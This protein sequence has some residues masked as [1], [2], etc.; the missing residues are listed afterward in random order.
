MKENLESNLYEDLTVRSKNVIIDF[1]GVN[2]ALSHFIEKRSFL[3]IRNCGVKSEK[4]LAEFFLILEE[5]RKDEF[6]KT[7]NIDLFNEYC[8]IVNY[9]KLLKKGLAKKAQ[10]V[11]AELELKNSCIS[12]SSN[13]ELI[14]KCKSFGISS[15]ITPQNHSQYVQNELDDFFSKISLVKSS[16][17]NLKIIDPSEKNYLTL[18]DVKKF[19]N[20]YL[21]LKNNLSQRAINILDHIEVE[22][23][24][25]NSSSL[26]NLILKLITQDV[27]F[28]EYRNSGNKTASEIQ[29]FLSY[30]RDLIQGENNKNNQK[31]KD[32]YNLDLR[33]SIINIF[34]SFVINEE[35]IDEFI[36]EDEY[37]LLNITI[38]FIWLDTNL[39]TKKASTSK[40]LLFSEFEKN[41]TLTEIA[42]K[43]VLSKERVRQVKENLINGNYV[44]RIINSVKD[45]LKS[46]SPINNS[47]YAD[48]INFNN[49]KSPV[50]IS[51]LGNYRPTKFLNKILHKKIF[52]VDYLLINSI[53]KRN[54][55]ALNAQVDSIFIKRSSTISENHLASFFDWIDLQIVDFESSQLDYNLPILVSRFFRENNIFIDLSYLNYLV[56]IIEEITVDFSGTQIERKGIKNKEKQQIIDLIYDFISIQNKPVKTSEIKSFLIENYI[57]KS[58]PQ[59]LVILNNASDYFTSFGHGLW[60]LIEWKHEGLIGG[61]LRDIIVNKLNQIENP[62][63]ISE[64]LSYINQ[65]RNTNER[66]VIGNLKLDE[67]GNFIIFNC[68]FIGLS[69]KKYEK[70]WFDLPKVVG[71]HFSKKLILKERKRHGV[72]LAK[73][74][75]NKYGYPL[76]HVE[77]ILTRIA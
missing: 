6:L 43:V 47:Y 29:S 2:A 41:Y 31:D 13:Y 3:G 61:S 51:Y 42:A 35:V 73:Y 23:Q 16:T 54:H 11:L 50:N 52:E 1:G 40:L 76:I 7:K 72:N 8:E 65:F 10:V 18:D 28:H 19:E 25:A 12:I 32:Q 63:H 55:T 44:S 49:F 38:Y 27:N 71:S 74:L 15:I 46:W 77:Y 53:I 62:I 66:N 21:L 39:N 45:N 48:V 36:K 64:I 9:Y 34:S 75:S 58:T 26:S 70:I 22:F 4:E 56:E 24:I 5:S 33:S 17:E 30:F 67:H 20:T 57:E 68:G 59:L 37:D 14:K 69:I 60:A